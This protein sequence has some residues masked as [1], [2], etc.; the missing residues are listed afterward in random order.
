[1][2]TITKKQLA[3]ELQFGS[4]AP[5]GN[6]SVLRYK[7]D[8]TAAGVYTEGDSTSAIGTT[9]TVILGI[10]PAGFEIHG[11][12][13][14]VSD[15]FKASSTGK[16]G[17]AYKDGVDVT[18]TPQ[19]D[20]YFFAALAMDAAGRTYANNTAV[21]PVKLPKDAYLTYTNAVAAQDAVGKFDLLVEGILNAAP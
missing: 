3:Q 5:Y 12:L 15:A 6:K 20:D 7:M 13:A 19:D 17:W 8:T 9:D 18:A 1:M 16:I 2:A 11:A 10:L 21:R 4:G 14:I